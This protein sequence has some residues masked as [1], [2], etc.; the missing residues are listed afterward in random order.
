LAHDDMDDAPALP[1]G[2]A[3][4]TLEEIRVDRSQSINPQRMPQ[5]AFELYSVPSF[6]GGKPEIVT[7][8]EIGSSKQSVEEESVL[9]CKINPRINRVWVVGSHSPHP[10]I[11]STEWIPFFQVHEVDPDYLCYFMQQNAF[12]DFL[13]LHTSEIEESLA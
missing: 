5:R 3:W 9:L 10:K 4:T 2:W 12:R 1:D 8:A 6:S 7:G 11:A 13:V